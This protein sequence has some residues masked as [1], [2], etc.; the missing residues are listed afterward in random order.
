MRA[1]LKAL[2]VKLTLTLALARG[3][4]VEHVSMGRQ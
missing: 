1:A 3:R 4:M 2:R